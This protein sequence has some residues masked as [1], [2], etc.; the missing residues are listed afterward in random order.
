LDEASKDKKIK[1]EFGV[2]ENN[3]R[4]QK[5]WIFLLLSIDV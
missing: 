2:T 5:Q 1:Q 3:M 4:L